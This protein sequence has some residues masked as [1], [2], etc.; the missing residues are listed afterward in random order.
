MHRYKGSNNSTS[1]ASYIN[2]LELLSIN[3]M[4]LVGDYV[5]M[6]TKTIF[7]IDKINIETTPD[8]FKILIKQYN[9]FLKY[10]KSNYDEFLCLDKY[11]SKGLWFNI[12][13][14]SNNVINK[15]FSG[16]KKYIISKKM[17]IANLNKYNGELIG[18]FIDYKTKVK[19]TI[20]GFD[21]DI[22]PDKA[23]RTLEQFYKFKSNVSSNGDCY[24]GVVSYGN[25]GFV[26]KIKTFDGGLVCLPS[27]GYNDFVRGRKSFFQYL[28]TNC[29]KMLSPYLGFTCKGEFVFKNTKFSVRC[30]NLSYTINSYKIF[31]QKV[32]SNGD[33]ILSI[34][35][36]NATFV[37]EIYTFDGATI[38]MPPANYEMFLR[39]RT[40]L[41]DCFSKSQYKKLSPYKGSN[42]KIL[43]DFGC[44]HGIQSI[45]PVN[46]CNGSACPICNQ[47]LGEL[48]ILNYLYDNNID[49]IRE[50]KIETDIMFFKKKR[51]D[52]YLPLYNLIIEVHGVQHYEFVEHFHK[53]EEVFLLKKE[54]DTKKEAFAR[55]MGYNYMIIDYKE[56]DPCLSLNRFKKQ[57]NNFISDYKEED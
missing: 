46:L 50:Y 35:M 7:N 36:K 26:F 24:C 56:A 43:V 4:R 5:N 25:N 30:N 17:F 29:I 41:L 55:E 45:F 13:T 2:M 11:D 15:N 53:T 3:N 51:Y 32:V 22:I 33:S 23:I 6:T 1:I 42:E 19:V 44:S 20:E 31:V 34:K 54:I 57:F 28:N 18:D 12:K 14:S 10:I 8:K 9:N 27:G 40:K 16:Y 52:I 39:A 37:Y 49:F 47:S 48:S 21:F 38:E